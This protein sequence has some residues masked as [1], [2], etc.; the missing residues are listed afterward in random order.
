MYDDV[1]SD[2]K[3]KKK[4]IGRKSC[5]CRH[6]KNPKINVYDFPLLLA[7]WISNHVFETKP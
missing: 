7:L 2:V 1:K 3:K 4:E 6:F 5:F